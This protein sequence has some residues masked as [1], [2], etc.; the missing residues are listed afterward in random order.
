MTISEEE[1]SYL[2]SLAHLA[3]SE[4]EKEM[5]MGKLDQAIAMIDAVKTVNTTGL[6]ATRTPSDL[7]NQMR[8]DRIEPTHDR[9]DYLANV[10]QKADD[11]VVVPPSQ[12][13]KEGKS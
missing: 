12:T 6:E 2:G 9:A 5:F 11:W 13:I 1:L 7:T 10:S 8:E 4:E 3:F